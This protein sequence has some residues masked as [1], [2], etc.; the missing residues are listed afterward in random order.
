MTPPSV[1]HYVLKASCDS[2]RYDGCTRQPRS[3]GAKR[4]GYTAA[5]RRKDV[6]PYSTNLTDAE[7]NLVAD[8]FERSPGQRG[9]PAHYSRRELVNACS[10]VLRTG[11]TWRLLPETFPPWQAVYKAFARWVEAGVF[12]QMQD[13]LREQ[14]RAR[15]GRSSTSTAAVIDAQSDRASPQGL[16][17]DLLTP[18]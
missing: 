5:H 9:T 4:Y 16:Y 3:G 1:E 8:L 15:M 18:R 2:S 7:W 11:C 13:R 14:W 10:Y 6:S 12:E 17:L